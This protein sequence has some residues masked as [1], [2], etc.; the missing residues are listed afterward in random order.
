MVASVGQTLGPFL[1]AFAMQFMGAGATAL[2]QGQKKKHKIREVF[3]MLAICLACLRFT[4]F[5]CILASAPAN[6]PGQPGRMLRRFGYQTTEIGAMKREGGKGHEV[7]EH[8]VRHRG[9]IAIG[10]MSVFVGRFSISACEACSAWMFE[11][12]YFWGERRI[13]YVQGMVSLVATLLCGSVLVWSASELRVVGSISAA[14]IGGAGFLFFSSLGPIS[15]LGSDLL[16]RP[17]LTVLLSIVDGLMF[18]NSPACL[19][20]A[21]LTFATLTSEEVARAMAPPMMLPLIRRTARLSYACVLSGLSMLLICPI[22]YHSWT[23]RQG[24]ER[25]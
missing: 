25:T 11:V 7:G 13:G 22:L 10:I 15:L 12:Q 1:S 16:L 8:S 2:V 17:S 9:K 4:S 6:K 24:E 18:E 20:L 14:I 19:S 23:S 21:G 5:L 3:S